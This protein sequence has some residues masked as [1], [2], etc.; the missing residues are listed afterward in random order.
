MEMNNRLRKYVIGIGI[1]SLVLEKS[2][3]RREKS[4]TGEWKLRF[5]KD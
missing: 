4:P 1:V 3:E 2:E 5:S